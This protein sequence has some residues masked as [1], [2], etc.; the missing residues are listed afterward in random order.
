MLH[1]VELYKGSNYNW[2]ACKTFDQ[3]KLLLFVN[4]TDQRYWLLELTVQ[5]TVRNYYT[6][7]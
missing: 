2:S 3:F 5:L 4:S 6:N 7:S 1:I